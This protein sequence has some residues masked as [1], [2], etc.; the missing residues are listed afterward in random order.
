[1]MKKATVKRTCKETGKA[2]L[3]ELYFRDSR[4]VDSTGLDGQVRRVQ[5]SGKW[6]T[7]DGSLVDPEFDLFLN[8]DEEGALYENPI[9]TLEIINKEF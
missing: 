3:F 1:M 2:E 4:W 8:C 5:E 9:F 7:E 6:F